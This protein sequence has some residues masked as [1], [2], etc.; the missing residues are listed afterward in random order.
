MASRGAPAKSCVLTQQQR[1]VQRINS[2]RI[3]AKHNKVSTGTRLS[4]KPMIQIS[5]PIFSRFIESYE[6]VEEEGGADW[7]NTTDIPSEPPAGLGW[8][9]WFTMIVFA[10]GKQK[11][12]HSLGTFKINS[13]LANVSQLAYQSFKTVLVLFP[14]QRFISILTR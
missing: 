12:F 14:F 1:N 7:N 10:D 13:P 5:G 6:P 9:L 4:H 11:Y 8:D 2:A 3:C